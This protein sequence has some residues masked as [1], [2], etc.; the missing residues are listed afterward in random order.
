M[1]ALFENIENLKIT[2]VLHKKS[3]LYGSNVGR[4]AHGFIIRVHGT[5]QYSFDDRIITVNE[6]EMAFIPKGS[7]YSFRQID[8]NDAVCTIINVDG[9]FGDVVPAKYSLKDFYNADYIMHH[10]AD[11]WKFGNCAQKYECYSIV[12]NLLSYIANIENQEYE[13]KKKF[14][15]IA[16][17]VD[18]LKRNIYSCELKIDELHHLCGV[19]DTYFRKLFV[20]KFGTSP[21]DY[22]IM[23]RV[24]HA[25]DVIDSGEFDTVK[26]LA[27]SIGYKDPLYFGKV[28][29]Q[30][31]GTSPAKMNKQRI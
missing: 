26:K 11:L 4:K 14:D 3:K 6:S 22:V 2:S 20:S 27:L 17:A 5:M 24:S 8:G 18:Y 16:P 10:L 13:D 31:Y 30:H 21:K 19:S 23:K 1:K 7:S 12:Y 15:I 28:F 29:K 9:D 25:K